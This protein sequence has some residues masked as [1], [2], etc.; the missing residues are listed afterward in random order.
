MIT[1]VAE[2]N[3]TIQLLLIDVETYQFVYSKRTKQIEEAYTVRKDFDK[4]Y[5]NPVQLD[6]VELKYIVTAYRKIK[7]FLESK[8]EN[9]DSNR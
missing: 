7:T 5:Y 1:R 4:T 9:A 8:N 3:R 6:M 2:D